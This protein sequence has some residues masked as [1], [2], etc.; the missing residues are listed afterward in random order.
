MKLTYD[1]QAKTVFAECDCGTRIMNITY[2]K[3]TDM[4]VGT[5]TLCGSIDELKL[6]PVP[7]EMVR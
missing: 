5:C 1:E 6:P 3:D 7:E 2:H 4:L